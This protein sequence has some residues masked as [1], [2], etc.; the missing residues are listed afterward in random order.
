MILNYLGRLRKP[1][2]RFLSFYKNLRS[3]YKHVHKAYR[4]LQRPTSRY[5]LASH[6]CSAAVSRVC[7]RARKVVKSAWRRNLCCIRKLYPT[8][9]LELSQNCIV[10]R[11]IQKGTC[12]WHYGAA[13]HQLR[14]GSYGDTEKASALVPQPA[15]KS[16]VHS[17]VCSFKRCFAMSQVDLS[18]FNGVELYVR[19]G[20]Y[21]RNF[22]VITAVLFRK[23]WL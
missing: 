3:R 11:S 22:R 10:G 4:I 18:G 8:I 6:G 2:I 14:R 19:T 1:R 7:R 21:E 15:L 16:S 17:F 13:P 12:Y 9:Q 23:F 5:E 20:G